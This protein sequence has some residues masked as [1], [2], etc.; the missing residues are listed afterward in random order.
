[1]EHAEQQLAKGDRLQASEK[2]WGAVAHQL[3][4][5]AIQ[6]GWEYETHQQVYAII[7]RIAGETDDPVLV[8]DLFS[9]AN[10]LHRNYY[11]DAMPLEDLEYEIGRVKELLRILNRPELVSQPSG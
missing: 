1:M 11:V 3:K 10:G 7:K 5:I 8:R 2:A 6:R 9:T 4:A